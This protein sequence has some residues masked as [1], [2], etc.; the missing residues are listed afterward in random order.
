MMARC[1]DFSTVTIAPI[2]A[3]S[4][5]VSCH[6]QIESIERFTQAKSKND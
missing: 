5:E 6:L 2:S 1:T 3:E 4:T